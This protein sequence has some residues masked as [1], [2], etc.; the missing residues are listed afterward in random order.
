MLQI[1]GAVL[2][3]PDFSALPG[4]FFGCSAG[5]FLWIYRKFDSFLCFLRRQT[6]QRMACI[7]TYEQ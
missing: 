4:P 1:P 7:V 3:G 6:G 5:P 2:Y